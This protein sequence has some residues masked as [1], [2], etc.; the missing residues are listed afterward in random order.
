MGGVCPAE[1][2]SRHVALE[3]LR[4]EFAD[5]TERPTPL[6]TASRNQAASGSL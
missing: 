3:V 5:D 6:H 1:D 2:S 4:E